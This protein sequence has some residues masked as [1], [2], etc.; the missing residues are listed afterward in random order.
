MVHSWPLRTVHSSIDESLPSLFQLM[1][2]LVQVAELNEFIYQ[3]FS[4][5]VARFGTLET[6]SQAYLN[7]GF[8]DLCVND[9][10]YSTYLLCRLHRVC[11]WNNELNNSSSLEPSNEV[12][13][14]RGDANFDGA[15]W[16][17]FAFMRKLVVCSI[18]VVILFINFDRFF[19][20]SE[21]V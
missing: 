17:L 15:F 7:E 13:G 8:L 19:W 3:V 20:K 5:L 14:K 12:E 4:N 18:L 6:S 11:S 2:T 10:S 1:R 21:D 9:W 16:L